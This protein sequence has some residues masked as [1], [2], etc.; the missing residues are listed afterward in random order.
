MSPGNGA[1]DN[2]YLDTHHS[3][4]YDLGSLWTDIRGE[5][6]TPGTLEEGVYHTP[7]GI[8]QSIRQERQAT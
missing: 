6:L 7:I 1:R 8:H 5:G 2:G 4:T 3:D